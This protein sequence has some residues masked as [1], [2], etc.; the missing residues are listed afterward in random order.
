MFIGAEK[1]NGIG[2]YAAGAESTG[3]GTRF[4]SL[5][6]R[7][8]RGKRGLSACGEEG[9]AGCRRRTK[10]RRGRG[11]STSEARL[12]RPL[13]RSVSGPYLYQAGHL[14]NQ[15]PRCPSDGKLV[16]PSGRANRPYIEK[17]PN[18]PRGV[19][20]AGAHP[21]IAI[22]FGGVLLIADRSRY[23]RGERPKRNE[24][25]TSP[26]G[27]VT[28]SHPAAGTAWTQ[29]AGAG[30][31][32]GFR[33]RGCTPPPAPPGPVT[34]GVRGGICRVFVRDQPPGV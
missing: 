3:S 9:D 8:R 2:N 10:R 23:R 16:L 14:R 15:T 26:A 20:L 25:R 30:G 24:P 33:G 31:G 7:K 13:S 27:L 22:R 12:L 29:E 5:G 21:P 28:G 19:V 32:K 34:P 4:R 18:I 1:E 17:R 6:R 11:L